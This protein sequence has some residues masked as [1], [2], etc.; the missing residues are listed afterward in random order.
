MIEEFLAWEQ[1]NQLNQLNQVSQTSQL[2]LNQSVNLSLIL[3]GLYFVSYLTTKK[4]FYIGAFLFIELYGL[5]MS[6]IGLSAIGCFVGY[7]SLYCICYKVCFEVIKNI[8]VT[9]FYGIMILFQTAMAGDAYFYPNTQT[10]IYVSYEYV[11]FV[12]HLCVIVSVANFRRLQ[13][14]MGKAVNGVFN[15]F[16]IGYSLSFCYNSIISNQAKK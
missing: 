10:L 12:I 8:K 13:A 2:E 11:V 6:N 7:A 15:M 16:D 3:I 14:F 1:L 4:G 9:L 5:S